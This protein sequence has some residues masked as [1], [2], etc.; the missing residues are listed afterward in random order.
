MIGRRV[1]AATSMDHYQIYNF[2]IS[3]VYSGE[4]K[5]NANTATKTEHVHLLDVGS[6]T[7]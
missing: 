2:L 7:Q 6:W 5:V 4:L 1:K 3:A